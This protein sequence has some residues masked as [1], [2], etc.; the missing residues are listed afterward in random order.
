MKAG[1]GKGKGAAFEREVCK[2]LSLWLSH[3][4]RDDL[5]WRSAMSGGRATIQLR[6]NK[7]NRAQSGDISAV[8]QLAYAFCDRNFVEIKHYGDLSIARGLVSQ[9]GALYNFWV[10]ACRE[11]LRYNQQPVLIAR[12]NLYPTLAI[13]RLSDDVFDDNPLLTVHRWSARVYLF[14]EVT[15]AAVKPVRRK[16]TVGGIAV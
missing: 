6:S 9:V 7:I 16:G 2:R 15:R 1:G 8:D 14:D 4:L 13:T 10:V 11:A 3:G 5:L 12:Q